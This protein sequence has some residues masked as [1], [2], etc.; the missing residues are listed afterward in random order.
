MISRIK[1][2]ME[3]HSFL[4]KLFQYAEKLDWFIFYIE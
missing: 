1:Y 4:G 3:H 2:I